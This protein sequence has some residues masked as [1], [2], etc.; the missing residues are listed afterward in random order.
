MNDL[1]ATSAAGS[2]KVWRV[3]PAYLL[4]LLFAAG[5]AAVAAYG[6]NSS[7]FMQ[8]VIQMA[9]INAIAAMG[10]NISMGFAGLVS[11]GHAG[12][13]A[14]GAY[15]STLAM[16][17]LDVPYLV[18]LPLGAVAA[19]I[20]GIVIGVPALRLSSLYIAMVTFGFG[21]AVNLLVLNW[22]DLTRGPNG[23]TV[24]PIDMFGAP[25]TSRGLF[26]LI[27]VVFAL[28]SFICWNIRRTFIGRAFIALRGSTIAAQSVGV[29][30]AAYKTIAFGISALFGGLA[31]GLYAALSGF[32]N[33]DS[34]TFGISVLYVVMAVVG[35][36]GTLAGPIV[37]AVLLTALPEFLRAFAQYKEFIT[38]VIL[39]ACMVLMPGGLVGLAGQ[40]R[41]RLRRAPR[42]PPS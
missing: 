23:L 12:F 24:P 25:L 26:L 37:G 36:I 38:G 4:P 31:G 22:T 9:M 39:L 8:F 35:G 34:F 1:D 10:V 32:I 19:A 18:A 14:I 30:V 5:L 41:A 17:H 13:V 15:V 33:P 20:A 29:P 3:A 7:N 2:D 16:L 42:R 6:L 21:Q 28:V 11:I 27:T 40:A